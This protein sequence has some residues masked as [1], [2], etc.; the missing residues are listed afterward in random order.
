[1]DRLL[2]VDDDID[3]LAE[4][5]RYFADQGYDIRT[6]QD[7][8]L[9]RAVFDDFNPALCLV[10][11]VMP[12]PSG[13]VFCKEIVDKSDC[14]VI[15]MSSLSD[16]ETIIALLEI[17]ADDYIVK[18]YRFPEMLARV[19]AVLRRR[20]GTQKPKVI[21]RLGPWTLEFEDRVL[22]HDDGY[23]VRVTLTEME[24]LRFLIASPGTIFSRSDILAISRT[25]QH[26]GADDRSVDNLVKRL[27]RKIETDP[28]NAR[29]IVTVWGK[30]YRID[31]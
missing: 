25:R 1:M 23:T 30:G 27:R 15:M 6:A 31:P 26:G 10:D 7:V 17:G 21:D 8:P 22:R 14:G 3:L 16:S 5:S 12:G 29:Y 9:A 28:A 4:V 18:P 11:I 24:V 20:G 19:R 13:R 2:F